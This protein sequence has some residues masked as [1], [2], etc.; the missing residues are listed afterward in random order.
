MDE[1][2]SFGE[3][4]ERSERHKKTRI[5]KQCRSCENLVSHD[6]PVRKVCKFDLIHVGESSWKATKPWR[7]C[8]QNQPRGVEV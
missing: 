4:Y 6:S 1:A 5:S 2:Y 8:L 3:V 7:T